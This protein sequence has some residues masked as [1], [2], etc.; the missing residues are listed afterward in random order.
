MQHFDPVAFQVLT[1]Q[2]RSKRHELG[3]SAT[4]RAGKRSLLDDDPVVEL[5]SS[6][7]IDQ[8]GDARSNRPNRWNRLG[9]RAY[10]VNPRISVVGEADEVAVAREVGAQLG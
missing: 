1:S 9:A 7:K 4:Q 10:R 2:P 5:R 6:A 3:Q 8:S